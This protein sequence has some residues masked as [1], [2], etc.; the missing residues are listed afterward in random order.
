[1]GE[2]VISRRDFLKAAGAGAVLVGTTMA[3][4]ACGANKPQGNQNETPKQNSNETEKPLPEQAK[5]KAFDL[6]LSAMKPH[7]GK[8]DKTNG[9]ISHYFG[10]GSNLD[11]WSSEIPNVLSGG[12]SSVVLTGGFTDSVLTGDEQV[13]GY[14]M[15]EQFEI[16]NLRVAVAQD[17][18]PSLSEADKANGIQWKGLVGINYIDRYK[19]VFYKI[20]EPLGAKRE[21]AEPFSAS[22]ETSLPNFSSWIDGAI[23]LSAQLT[24]NGWEI[25]APTAKGNLA[26]PNMADLF[27]TP[28]C[29]GDIPGCVE[30]RFAP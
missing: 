18:T 23:N 28:N 6:F 15:V 20:G 21:W 4:E 16:N 11:T 12:E 10:S 29:F 27:E 14:K 5:I 13:T 9:Q 22:E 30:N 25:T 8:I 19:G 3:L 2:K 24:N 1:M 17:L 7:P 26:S